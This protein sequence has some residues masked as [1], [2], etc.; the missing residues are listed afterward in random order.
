MSSSKC[1][2]TFIP[3]YWNLQVPRTA[4]EKEINLAY[5]RLIR[6][7]HPDKF[8]GNI[9]AQNAVQEAIILINAAKETLLSPKTRAQYNRASH[10]IVDYWEVKFLESDRVNRN[11]KPWFWDYSLLHEHDVEEESHGGGHL[12]AATWVNL[13]HLVVDNALPASLSDQIWEEA[14]SFRLKGRKAEPP[15][16]TFT[17]YGPCQT[18]VVSAPTKQARMPWS[19]VQSD[20]DWATLGQMEDLFCSDILLIPLIMSLPI[21]FLLL[22]SIYRFFRWIYGFVAK[23]APVENATENPPSTGEEFKTPTPT[24]IEFTTENGANEVIFERG[25]RDGQVVQWFENT[26]HEAGRWSPATS[27][28]SMRETCM[29]FTASNAPCKRRASPT[30]GSFGGSEPWMCFQHKE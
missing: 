12:C 2:D 7:V 23:K 20:T 22:R 18:L 19:L 30:T 17:F 21:W 3:H 11:K 16:K 10:S 27:G 29:G 25:K 1:Y 14:E 8:R 4:S 15:T 5:R 26:S 13:A 6:V 24:S 9:D 28:A